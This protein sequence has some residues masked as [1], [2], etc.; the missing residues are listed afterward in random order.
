MQARRF[1]VLLSVLLTSTGCD[2]LRKGKGDADAAAAVTPPAAT[3]SCRPCTHDGKCTPKV[4]DLSTVVDP[5]DSK[6]GPVIDKKS[7]TVCIA[8]RG[9]DCRASKRCKERGECAVAKEDCAASS[10]GDCRASDA[11]KAQG[12]CSLSA[13]GGVCAVRGEADCKQAEACTQRGHCTYQSL[14]PDYG[15]CA[16]ST[17]ADC[18]RAPLCKSDGLC[19]LVSASSGKVCGA[20]AADCKAS[21]VCKSEG[22]CKADTTGFHGYG[23]VKG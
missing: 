14:G 8:T 15:R 16:P 11:C 9:E 21:A 13:A 12:N 7:M 19:S 5:G 17:A 20:T 10:A 1:L 2:R 4:V 23:C 3:T 22:R 18:K 6:H